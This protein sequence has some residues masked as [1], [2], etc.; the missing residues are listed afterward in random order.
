M[1][2]NNYPN[3]SHDKT[4]SSGLAIASFVFGLFFFIPRFGVP[5]SLLAVSC[6][7][8]ALNQI[9]VS[10]NSV[11]GK[12]MAKIGLLLGTIGLLI[13]FARM[14][15]LGLY[16]NSE[17]IA[18]NSKYAQRAIRAI[19]AGSEIYYLDKGE[20]PTSFTILR[21]YDTQYI[22]KDY[23]QKTVRGYSYHCQF[24]Q[25]GYTITATPEKIGETGDDIYA[26][27]TGG[28]FSTNNTP[29]E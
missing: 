20:Y 1:T 19:S 11:A 13:T 6:G 24:D 23:C 18:V 9:R 27:Q 26:I 22:D 5:C 28:T 25:L 29:H 17:P 14:G 3:H 4:A 2:K 7:I 21:E 8:A 12:N 10:G 16:R 15:M